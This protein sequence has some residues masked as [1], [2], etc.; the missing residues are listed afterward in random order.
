ML[1]ELAWVIA[2]DLIRLIFKDMDPVWLWTMWEVGGI[3]RD[4]MIEIL[5]S[6]AIL[7]LRSRQ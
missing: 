4:D 7:K 2:R 1:S 3:T 5:I 6:L